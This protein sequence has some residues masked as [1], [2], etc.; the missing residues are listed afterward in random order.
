[1]RFM[2][3]MIPKGYEQAK[4]GTMPDAKAVAAMMKYNEELQKAGVL[5]SLEGL[6]PPSAGGAS[7]SPAASRR[8]PTGPLPK[9]RKW[10]A[11]SG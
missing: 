9:R 7:R 1:M 5:L 8:S 4:P 10:S 6:H 2:M 11:V 3:L